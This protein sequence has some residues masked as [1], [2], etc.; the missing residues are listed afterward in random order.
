V[1][2]ELVPRIGTERGSQS[3][4]GSSILSFGEIPGVMARNRSTVVD[5]AQDG[6]D[7]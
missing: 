5:C 7:G 3:H 2:I 1:L 6:V 4:H